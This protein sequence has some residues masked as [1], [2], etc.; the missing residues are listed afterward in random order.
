MKFAP[1]ILRN[2]FRNKMRS[3]LTVMLMAAI[4]FFVATLLSVLAN[5]DASG[6]AVFA[7]ATIHQIV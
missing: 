1:L 2:L 5:F 7:R 6:P 4:F 3:L